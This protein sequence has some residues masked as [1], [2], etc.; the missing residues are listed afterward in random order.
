MP[1][2]IKLYGNSN[3]ILVLLSNGDIQLFSPTYSSVPV[4]NN[5]QP[6]YVFDSERDIFDN[7]FPFDFLPH[8]ILEDNI[9]L[10]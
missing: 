8:D 7:D 5:E 2:K 3:S 1:Y 4:I 10:L 6:L 9:F